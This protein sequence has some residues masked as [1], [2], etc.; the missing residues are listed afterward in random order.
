MH[1]SKIYDNKNNIRNVQKHCFTW[2]QG[3]LTTSAFTSGANL[4]EKEVPVGMM[5]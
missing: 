4:K 5:V 1:N 2:L 3:H